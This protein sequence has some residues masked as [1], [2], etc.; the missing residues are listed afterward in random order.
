MKDEI[1]R[2]VA[3]TLKG[4]IHISSSEKFKKRNHLVDLDGI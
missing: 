3:R 4:E 1:N 2:H